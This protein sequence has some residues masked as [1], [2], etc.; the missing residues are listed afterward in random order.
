LGIIFTFLGVYWLPKP[1]CLPQSG[2]CQVMPLH[3]MP[4]TFSAM[5]IW[6]MQK[7]QRQVQQKGWD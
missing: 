7:P 4:Q 3:D 2:H 6:Q 5:Q 1:F